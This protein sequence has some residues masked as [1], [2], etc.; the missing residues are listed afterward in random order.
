M[1]QRVVGISWTYLASTS[2]DLFEAGCHDQRERERE[3][4]RER[5]RER[6]IA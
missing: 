3:R 2:A 4:D 5:E 6:E 1:N